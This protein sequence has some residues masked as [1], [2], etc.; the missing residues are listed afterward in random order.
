MT[1]EIT[2]LLINFAFVFCAYFLVYPKLAGNDFNKIVLFDSL[3]SLLMLAIVAYQYWGSAYQFN[4]LFIKLNWFWYALLTFA[5]IE[6][7]LMLWYFKK[8]GVLIA[9]NKGSTKQS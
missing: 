8:H 5:A 6:I 4:A 2:V 1:P 7:P 9:E 3:I